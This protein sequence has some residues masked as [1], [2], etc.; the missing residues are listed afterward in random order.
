M[1]LLALVL[2]IFPLFSSAQKINK[3]NLANRPTAPCS[4]PGMTPESAI[5]VCGTTTFRQNNVSSCEGPPISGMGACGSNNSSDNAFWYKFHCYQAGTLG[6]LVKPIVLTD[7][8]DWELFDV[9]GV[10]VSQ[11]YT[12]ENLMVSLNL[13]GSTLN[14]AT[15]CTAAGIDSINCGGATNIVNRLA[16]LQVGHDY[17]LMVNNWSNSG[18]GYTLSFFGGTA[19]ITENIPPSITS[20]AATCNTSQ[21]KVTFSKD[22]MCNSVTGNGSE[23]VIT[24][25]T[26][27][28]N[29]VT[30]NCNLGFS[31]ST[32]LMINLQN[33]LAAGNYVLTVND[34]D[35]SNTFLDACGS[36]MPSAVQIPFTITAVNAAEIN[37][38][39]YSGCAPTIL[40]VKLT[41][42]VWCSSVIAQG[43]GSE[44]TIMPGNIPIVFVQAI[45]NGTTPSADLLRINL[46]NPLP[47]GNYQ[48][49]INSGID[50]NTFIDTCGNTMAAGTVPFTI[51][52]TT[53]API[54][55]SIVY[56]ECHR[57]RLV[58]NFNKP[59]L[60]TSL[61]PNG[62]EFRV[63]TGGSGG[64]APT[65]IISNCGA[66]GYTSQVSLFFANNLPTQVFN[67]MVF[68]GADG[69][70]LSDTC[71]VFM[72]DGYNVGLTPTLPPRP[73]FDSVQFDNCNPTFVKAF[74]SK[75]IKCNTV[76][77][78]GWPQF[79]FS[80][81]STPFPSIT[82]ASTDPATCSQGY[83]KWILFQLATPVTIAGSYSLF[84]GSFSGSGQVWDT[85]DMPQVLNDKITFTMLG[86]PSAAFTSQVKF[87]CVMDTVTFS[88]PG[89][90]GI[91]SWVWTFSD[92]STAIGQT[93]IRTFPVSTAN[94]TAQLI[95]TNGFCSDTVSNIITLGNA[96]H[97]EF[98]LAPKDTICINTPVNFTNNS[99]GNNL[100][101]LW[102]FGDNTQFAGQTPP[103]HV[104]TSSNIFNIK[105]AVTD[106]YGCTDT[107]GTLLNV[108][109]LPIIDFAGLGTQYCTDK[110]ISLTRVI[111]NNINSY[112]WDNGDGIII[113]NK[114][115]VQF[116]YANEAVYTI[117]L[118]GND[119]FCGTVSISKPVSIFAVPQINLGSDTVLCPAVT[120]PIGVPFTNGYNYLWSNGAT[121][122]QIVTDIVTSN[123]S[124]E[125]NNNG[126]KASDAISVK[127]LPACLIRVAG[128]FT[129][130]NDGLND[131]L[132]AINADL[133]KE[134]SLKIYNRFGELMFATQ[135]PLDGWNGY[136][137]GVRA[138]AGTYVWQLSY[139]DPWSFKKV[140]ESGTSILIR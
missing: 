10:P 39:T 48:L 26:N 94:I 23:F 133:A 112:T 49:V 19:N 118:T 30:S 44:F 113:N 114:P 132:K 69:N 7:D 43:A 96:F 137:K 103:P 99:T 53:S 83:T 35:D 129:P 63:N 90:N 34:G 89:G 134:F 91:N 32:E 57:D 6:F 24:N 86:K 108:A 125:V 70:T 82:S 67:V 31:A 14:G 109:A 107:A 126:C 121:T 136:Y 111:S 18:Q 51:T 12:N 38:I 100:Q 61:T 22:V 127:V 116:T 75:P 115:Q 102:L 3:I 58:V 4:L 33:P 71:Y 74:F 131:K 17:L 80:G 42:P 110:T 130:N 78:G 72:P 140:F 77:A 40:D 139:I 27:T 93:I 88:H 16:T 104:Y 79:H 101:Y 105:L 21:I 15:G 25:G 47:Y 60:C 13:Y 76:F 124:L 120:L 138:D 119:K 92:G 52:Q 87:A 45:C 73:I 54:F 66:N 9:T 8:Y 65:S 81:P 98:T 122:S 95:V 84:A 106:P 20:V 123:Y 135:N 62:S 117:S 5:P 29:T 59:V 41:K 68:N 50:G 64:M 28:I 11:V 85:C 56:D 36:A 1:R 2:F 37:T 128:A 97:A 46:Q 55:Q